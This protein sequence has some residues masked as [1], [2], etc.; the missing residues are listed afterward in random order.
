MICFKLGMMLAYD[1][2]QFDSSLNDLIFIWG[3]GKARICAVIL[4]KLHESTQ[5]LVMVVY[6]RK[7][8]VKMSL[9]MANMG[10]LRI[11]SSCFVWVFF[12]FLFFLNWHQDRVKD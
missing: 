12:S 3:H 11:C 1:T 8:T 9:S 7:M 10:H 2:L 6:V 5:M 4:L